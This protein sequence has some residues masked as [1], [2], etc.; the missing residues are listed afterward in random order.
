MQVFIKV[1]NFPKIT[2]Y[3]P[4]LKDHK[5]ILKL[6][7]IPKIFYFMKIFKIS[8]NSLNVLNSR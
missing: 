2:N 5:H 7:N 3:I 6:K 4:S 1:R 8:L